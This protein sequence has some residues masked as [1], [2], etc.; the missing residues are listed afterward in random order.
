MR[1]SVAAFCAALVV[2]MSF[3]AAKAET[4]AT[5]EDLPRSQLFMS[6]LKSGARNQMIIDFI[7]AMDRNYGQPCNQPHMVQLLNAFVVRPVV[8]NAGKP[9]P[10]AGIWSE[11]LS[12]QRCGRTS[13]VNIMF[14]AGQG[15]A[16]MPRPAELLPGMTV[17]SPELM[18]DSMP[19][20]SSGAV[21]A[22]SKQRPA[23]KECKT[24]RVT[25]TSGPTLTGDKRSEPNSI[26]GRMWFEIWTFDVCGTQAKVTVNFSE[27]LITK[28]TN[29]I[30]NSAP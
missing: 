13:V 29:I 25:D 30:V 17:A 23:A 3:V 1:L 26:V 9:A 16:G 5:N 10:E 21:L 4:L 24:T 2:I 20:A 7:G 27:N 11:K 22:A 15:P 18:R 28:G 19:M 6:Y 14:I 12:A 8:I